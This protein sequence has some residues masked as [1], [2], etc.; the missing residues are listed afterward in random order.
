[1][2][3]IR[4]R[5]LYGP[6]PGVRPSRTTSQA[7]RTS[8]TGSPMSAVSGIPAHRTGLNKVWGAAH[9]AR[10]KASR[11]YRAGDSSALARGRS[12]VRVKENMLRG[13]Q[14]APRRNR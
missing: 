2:S 10:N 9:M 1:M 14:R 4:H 12:A 11:E 5:N 13:T 3:K 7:A 6:A 8:R